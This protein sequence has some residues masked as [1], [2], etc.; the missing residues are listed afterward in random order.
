MNGRHAIVV[1]IGAITFPLVAQP[2]PLPNPPPAG[3]NRVAEALPGEAGSE[4]PAPN[5]S[6]IM[7]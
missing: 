2:A 7:V 6:P 1:A 5:R 4:R 3:P